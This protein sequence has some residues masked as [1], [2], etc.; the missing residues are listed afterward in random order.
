[1]K[2]VFCNIVNGVLPCHKIWEDDEHLAFLSIFPNT[3]GFSVV[4][5]KKIATILD[6]D[7]NNPYLEIIEVKKNKTFIAK[8]TKTFEEERNVSEK[9]P[10]DEIKINDLNIE[11]KSKKNKL[12]QQN[13]RERFDKKTHNRFSTNN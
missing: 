10:V 11:K 13:Y 1:M 5:T 9:A 6:L 12:N 7:E 3:K 2:C 4:I 8:K